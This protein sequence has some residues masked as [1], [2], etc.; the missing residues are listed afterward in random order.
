MYI[1]ITNRTAIKKRWDNINAG[2]VVAVQVNDLNID[3]KTMGKK[4][5]YITVGEPR[6]DVIVGYGGNVTIHFGSGEQP[7]SWLE[8]YDENKNVFITIYE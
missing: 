3:P 4:I 5:Q 7:I 8:A 6:R 1:D 2:D